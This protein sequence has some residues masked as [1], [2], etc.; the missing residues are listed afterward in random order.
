MSTRSRLFSIYSLKQGTHSIPGSALRL[1]DTGITGIQKCLDLLLR[2]QKAHLLSRPA[3]TM[4]WN[5]EERCRLGEGRVRKEHVGRTAKNR[6]EQ[7]PPFSV[8]EPHTAI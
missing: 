1:G 7:L 6:R 5:F 2:D 4:T 3:G 8:S